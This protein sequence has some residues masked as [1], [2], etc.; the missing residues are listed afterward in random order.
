MEPISDIFLTEAEVGEL[1]GIKIGR[2]VHGVKKTKL[3][4]QVDCLRTM[5]VPFF[6]NARG[7]PIIARAF[8]TGTKGEP[9]TRPKWQPRVLK[10]I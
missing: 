10:D 3:E 9:L 5:G 2:T 6:V 7:R 4:L 1:T 8:F